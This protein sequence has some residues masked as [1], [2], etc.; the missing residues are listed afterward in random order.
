MSE[1]LHLGE[2]YKAAP[3]PTFGDI[4]PGNF[5]YDQAPSSR[6]G[7]ITRPRIKYFK[8]AGAFQIDDRL[9]NAIELKRKNTF[10]YCYFTN[11]HQVESIE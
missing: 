7:F 1:G 5:F 3:R 11:S 10:S 2:D 6:D 9:V 4:G 8:L